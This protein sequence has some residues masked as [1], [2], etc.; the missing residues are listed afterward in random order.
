MNKYIHDFLWVCPRC[1]K[2]DIENGTGL[3]S[4]IGSGL[5]K[6]VSILPLLWL[7]SKSLEEEK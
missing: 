3:G 6:R 1:E 5:E 2:E 7:K 4:G